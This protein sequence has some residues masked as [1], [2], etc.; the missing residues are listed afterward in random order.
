VTPLRY[1]RL[2]S[3]GC[4]LCIYDVRHPWFRPL[5]RFHVWWLNR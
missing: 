2:I 3:D 5:Y 4:W 1:P